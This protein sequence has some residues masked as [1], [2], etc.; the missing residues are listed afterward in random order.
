[1]KRFLFVLTLLSH[2]LISQAFD[3]RSASHASRAGK[4]IVAEI[5]EGYY[6]N[7]VGLKRD[8]LK[9]AMHTIISKAHVL[10]YG[11]G[12]GKTWSGFYA[13]D[14]YDGYRVR[15]RY[16]NVAHYFSS[17]DTAAAVS[18][19]NIEHSFPKSWWGG[20]VNQAYKDL[21]NLFPSDT[22]SNSTKSNYAM[23][24]VTNVKSDNG[25]VKVGTG[26]A[27]SG[28]A[29]LWEPAD[30]WKG[31][32]ARTYFYMVTAYS[33]LTWASAGLDMLENDDWPTLQPWAC[34]LLLKWSR[35]DPVDDIEVERNEAVYRIQG[36]RNPYV[37]FPNL[38]E[39]VWGDSINVGFMTA[40]AGDEDDEPDPDMAYH[41]DFTAGSEGWTITDGTLPAGIS[42]V[43]ARD[44]RYGMKA[45]AY[46]NGTSL[47]AD[48]WLISPSI[49]L[50][51]LSGA[52]L[53]FMHTGRYFSD[54]GQ[55][56]TLWVS[57]ND[58]SDW[59][60]LEINAYMSG[61][62]WTFVRNTTSLASYCGS[63]IRIA[64]RYRSTTTAAPT[65]EISEVGVSGAD[66]PVMALK[67]GTAYTIQETRTLAGLTYTR[68]FRNT[69]WQPLYVPFSMSSSDWTDLG[70]EVARINCFYE[71]DD[72]DN[73]TIDRRA[74][75][76]LKV[77]N[78]RLK[79]GHPY[80]I[81]ARETGPVTITVSDP[82]VYPAEANSWDCRTFETEYT[83]Q[84]TYTPVSLEELT[85]AQG[86]VMSAGSLVPSLGGLNPMRWYMTRASR[87]GQLLP[88]EAEIKVFLQG[89]EQADGL[90]FVNAGMPDGDTYNLMGQRVDNQTKGLLI[91]NGRKV[92]VR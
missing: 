24:V 22:K 91:R 29:S 34:E 30:E 32:F 36:N 89:E 35:Q 67:D 63:V 88:E 28:N 42:Y 41:I 57:T 92:W 19:M 69:N 70:L 56:A 48:S 80:L 49:D 55:E 71:Y 6:D 52:E 16:S 47:A 15:D 79:P 68:E 82:T 26:P 61:E 13:T 8:E 20:S 1:M 59:A 11:S 40:P 38:A 10:A 53:T 3:S 23:G 14:R 72:D 75:E 12:A 76:I 74:L 85:A 81:R 21:F 77:R 31:D 9:G 5:P 64:F 33:N 60:P 44:N 43:W 45:S 73:G 4:A 86:Y 58:G 90:D 54:M 50:T 39:Y 78:G 84:G 37:D 66:S 7:A 62:D 51:A 25:Y 18:G 27:G 87:G 17:S 83:F 2:T 46:V 65:W